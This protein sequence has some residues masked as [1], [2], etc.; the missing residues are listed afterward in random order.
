MELPTIRRYALALIGISLISFPGW[1]QVGRWAWVG[2]DSVW[3]APG[4]F[5][6]LGVPA[7]ANRPPGLA[8]VVSWT[9][10]LG[11]FW[12]YGGS[13]RPPTTFQVGEMTDVWRYQ[14]GT[15]QWTW[16][17]GAGQVNSQGITGPVDAE[18]PAFRPQ[19]NIPSKAY[20]ADSSGNLWLYLTG[21]L[22]ELWRFNVK[23]RMWSI[24]ANG[25]A[26]NPQTPVYG[27][28]GREG[29][30][31]HPGNRIFSTAWCGKDGMLYLAGGK[32]QY[33]G[34]IGSGSNSMWR[35]NIRTARWAWLKGD[36]SIDPFTNAPGHYGIP[37]VPDSAN[38]PAGFTYAKGWADRQG[39]LWLYKLSTLPLKTEMWRYQPVTNA[40]TLMTFDT[41]AV[42]AT[43]PEDCYFSKIRCPNPTQYTVPYTTN[44]TDTLGRF[45]FYEGYVNVTGAPSYPHTGLW[46][47]DPA[48]RRWAS[49]NSDPLPNLP[50]RRGVRDTGSP[51]VSPGNRLRNGCWFD[52]A[53]NA[54]YLFGG[55]QDTLANSGGG[56]N[57][58]L[59][60][61][62]D[63]FRFPI[64]PA[65]PDVRLRPQSGFALATDSLCPG[66]ALSLQDTSHY[67]DS[68][69]VLAPG[70]AYDSVAGGFAY[71]TTGTYLV[72]QVACN[73]YFCDTSAAVPVV[74]RYD[75]ALCVAGLVGRKQPRLTARPNPARGI[76]YLDGL[77]AGKS[78][79]AILID[80]LGRVRK[81]GAVSEGAPLSL[82]GLAPGIYMLV[83]DGRRVRLAV[84]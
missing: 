53:G 8:G 25:S 44:W 71:A 14:K 55:L 77:P 29:A 48:L 1:G 84:E 52:K 70:A 63:F 59:P 32:R 75:N 2:G 23:T 9:D 74:V 5:G 15:G 64:D 22:S 72:R 37:G 6:T 68:S 13:V 38:S 73:L 66:E 36:T 46:C 20:W 12:L 81:A 69:Y 43:R 3:N 39:D 57:Q 56:N 24:R 34:Q 78:M 60:T 82:E 26:T 80:A 7:S 30:N 76:V 35:Y 18:N 79:E 51:S 19:F 28:R 62:N 45:W 27:I 58:V 40:W 4:H 61:L 41:N 54:L 49:V 10:S 31:V 17:N 16:V 11:N 65:C 33:A 67:Y 50:P 21:G 47:Y 42:D 83:A